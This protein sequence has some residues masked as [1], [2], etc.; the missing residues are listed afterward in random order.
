M[1][2]T[3]NLDDDVSAALDRLRRERGLGRS[4][5]VNE[6][7]RSGNE[8]P[9]ESLRDPMGYQ[10]VEAQPDIL[11]AMHSVKSPR[12]YAAHPPHP[13]RPTTSATAA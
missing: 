1:R 4:E 8:R 3:V 12:W 5:A 7:V 11:A 9:W 2:T 6:L 10:V 13:V